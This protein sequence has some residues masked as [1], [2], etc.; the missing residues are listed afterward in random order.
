MARSIR[1]EFEGAHYHVMA[2]G[3]CRNP[4]VR[5]DKDREMFVRTLA[6]ACERTG[7]RV[8]AWVLMGNHYHLFFETPEANLV[9]G[10][11]WMQNTY[12]RRFNV[13]NNEWGR[14]FGDRYKAISVEGSE[15]MYFETLMNYIHLNPVRAGLIDVRG[16]QSLRQYRWSS[17]ALGYALRPDDRP[18]WMACT[19]GLQTLGYD[20]SVGGR[21]QMIDELDARARAED[22]QRC[23]LVEPPKDRDRRRSNFRDGWYWGSEGFAENLIATKK[24]LFSKTFSPGYRSSAEQKSHGERE[25]EAI[26]E[27]GLK[28][29]GIGDIQLSA[30]PG[31]DQRKVAIAQRLRAQTTVSLR[32][33]AERLDMKSAG[34]VSH[35]L[36]GAR[37]KPVKDVLDK[38]INDQK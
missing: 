2:R 32:W 31:S 34:N 27:I 3:N 11:T 8:H 19:A 38:D 26:V 14:L 15:R 4:I 10:M 9:S 21:Q 37:R 30:L 1:I 33:I 17:V 16:G 12:T 13:K 5:D 6:Q 28:S 35:L 18:P 20:D 36:Y 24:S 7:W 23:G 25:A 22:R 29:E